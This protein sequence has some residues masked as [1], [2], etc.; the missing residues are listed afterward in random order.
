MILPTFGNNDFQFHYQ[1]PNV[2]L[3]EAFYNEIMDDWFRV[4][5]YNAQHLNYDLIKTTFRTGGYYRVN[6]PGSRISIL[7]MN[8]IGY[9]PK[10]KA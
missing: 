7:A 9:S 5:G 3:R 10:N 1:I 6:L 4:I 2:T 8:S